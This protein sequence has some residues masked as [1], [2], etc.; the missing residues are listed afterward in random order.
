MGG[1]D[2]EEEDRVTPGF[3]MSRDLLMDG[4]RMNTMEGDDDDDYDGA[5]MRDDDEEE[6]NKVAISMDEF[7]DDNNDDAD[8]LND[9]PDSG[10]STSANSKS[11]EN[12]F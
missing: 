8:L 9:K 12:L 5:P 6:E 1:E 10:T 7:N 4:E 11:I 3:K 2:D